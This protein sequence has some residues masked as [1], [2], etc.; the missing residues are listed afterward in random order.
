MSDDFFAA[1]VAP[2]TDWRPVQPVVDAARPATTFSV[3]S[4]TLVGLGAAL[5]GVL[6]C[7]GAWGPWF[8]VSFFGVSA[9][10]G[11]LNS[12]LEGRYALVLGLLGVVLGLVLGA[13]PPGTAGRGGVLGGLALVGVIGLIVVVHQDI[14]L[15]HI[16]SAISQSP[17]ASAFEAS[18][19]VHIGSGW[20]LWLD[21]FSFTGLIVAAGVALAV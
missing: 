1:P 20:G 10:V 9:N 11:G 8:S 21:G 16:T 12:E 18:A 7:I 19:G 6:A 4:G 2:P 17:N 13:A 14:H 3:S 5:A 15:S